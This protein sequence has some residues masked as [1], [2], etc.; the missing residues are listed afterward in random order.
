MTY[1]NQLDREH[2][3]SIHT[4]PTPHNKYVEFGARIPTPFV[5]KYK[6]RKSRVFQAK[7]PDSV[8][9][10]IRSNGERVSLDAET[11]KELQLSVQKSGN[12]I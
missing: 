3:E 10:W 1:S 12:K 7:Y 11:L 6:G 9:F 2:L 8:D 5:L 4:T